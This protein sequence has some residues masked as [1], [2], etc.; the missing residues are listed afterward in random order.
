[1]IKQTKNKCVATNTV[2]ISQSYQLSKPCL[3]WGQK[4]D[5]LKWK[6]QQRRDLEGEGC[7]YQGQFQ[8][9]HSE[10]CLDEAL[11]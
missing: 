1:M 3:H 2:V 5:K 6:T 7:N 11:Q 9:N 10:A 8:G 4:Y